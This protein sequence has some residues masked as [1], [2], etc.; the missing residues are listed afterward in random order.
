MPHAKPI[1][2][3]EESLEEPRPVLV[4][5]Q[6][7]ETRE[8][9]HPDERER[10]IGIDGISVRQQVTQDQ[11][12]LQHRGVTDQLRGLLPWERLGQELV[13]ALDV[14]V[15]LAPKLRHER[16]HDDRVHGWRS[17]FGRQHLTIANTNPRRS[18]AGDRERLEVRVDALDD[19]SRRATESGIELVPRLGESARRCFTENGAPPARHILVFRFS[20]EL[21]QERRIFVLGQQ[22]KQ[23]PAYA[24]E[25]RRLTIPPV[26]EQPPYGVDRSDAFQRVAFTEP[27]HRWA[28]LAVGALAER[29]ADCRKI[30]VRERGDWIGR[31]PR[32][33]RN[34]GYGAIL[35]GW[36]A[37]VE[38]PAERE[39][40][41]WG[42]GP[43][44]SWRR[45]SGLERHGHA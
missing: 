36:C 34:V 27:E 5:S 7:S 17:S 23:E 21:E 1:A 37:M 38:Q 39:F 32:E 18:H 15:V 12:W 25:R 22:P 6:E 8:H 42:R 16:E 29:E 33:S 30:S 19:A 35:N 41:G 2:I 9:L 4:A 3:V 20:R 44:R 40:D 43:R 28:P 26:L 45:R 31:G 11:V 24:R 13:Q 14:L 10:D